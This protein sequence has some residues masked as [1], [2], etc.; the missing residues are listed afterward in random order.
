MPAPIRVITH[1]ITAR[2]FVTILRGIYLKDVG[3]GVMAGEVALLAVFAV[4][5]IALSVR[6]FRKRIE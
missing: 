4:I 5:V 2:Y 6:K 3:L 1:I